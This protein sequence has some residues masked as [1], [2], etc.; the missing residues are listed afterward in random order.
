MSY[1]RIIFSCLF[2]SFFSLALTSQQDSWESIPGN[3]SDLAFGPQGY[4]YAITPDGSDLI[5]YD[6]KTGEWH[7]IPSDEAN[8]RQIEVDG[9]GRPWLL[10]EAGKIAYWQNGQWQEVKGG[11]KHLG[12]SPQG[13]VYSVSRGSGSVFRWNEG[14]QLWDPF[15]KGPS[16]AEKVWGS[17]D[18]NF[19]YTDAAGKLFFFVKQRSLSG[20]IEAQDLSW[21]TKEKSLY[22]VDPSGKLMRYSDATDK[23]HAI[24]NLPAKVKKVAVHPLTQKAWVIDETGAIWRPLNKSSLGGKITGPAG[25][26]I[27]G[28][29]LTIF[30]IGSSDERKT[31]IKTDAEG[32]WRYRTQANSV[33]VSPVKFGDFKTDARVNVKDGINESVKGYSIRVK[34]LTYYTGLNFVTKT[35]AIADDWLKKTT[36]SF[37]PDQPKVMV[38]V[39]G[40]TISEKMDLERKR[41]YALD[42]RDGNTSGRA[43]IL[44]PYEQT[45]TAAHMQFYWGY[46]F[47]RVLQGKAASDDLY[48]F[49]PVEGQERLKFTRS[50][51]DTHQRPVYPSKWT[52]AAAQ[53]GTKN[54]APLI[55]DGRT[56]QPGGIPPVSVMVLYR[57]GAKSFIEQT[58]DVSSQLYDS[59]QHYF[60]NLPLDQ[61]PA[62]YILGH[63]FGGITSR[64]LLNNS[65]AV[66]SGQGH[67]DANFRKAA[68][69]IRDRTVLLNT[70][71][72]PH[73]G[74]PVPAST[75]KTHRQVTELADAIRN[76]DNI[77]R[78]I[79]TT[80]T[81][82]RESFVTEDRN[83]IMDNLTSIANNVK[84]S[85]SLD[86][87]AS[88]LEEVADYVITGDRPVLDDIN[89]IR[90]IHDDFIT[91]QH[92]RRTDGSLIPVYTMT[93][94][95]PGSL[96]YLTE[97]PLA[98]FGGSLWNARHSLLD[99]KD[100]YNNYG[101]NKVAFESTFL[102]IQDILSGEDTW[103]RKYTDFEFG[104]R[105]SSK[106]T[107][108]LDM[109]VGCLHPEY[110]VGIGFGADQYFDSDGMVGFESG[111]ALKA[112]GHPELNYFSANREWKVGNKKE[113]G[114]WYR[115]YGKNYGITHPWDYDNHRS[116]CFNT[117]TAAFIHNYL[118]QLAGPRV[119]AGS[120]STM[121]GLPAK[122]GLKTS[123]ITVEIS[124][125]KDIR[126]NIDPSLDE[127]DFK[128]SV[129]I[130]DRVWQGG[131]V[132]EG[133][134]E[135]FKDNFQHGKPYVWTF[136]S[137]WIENSTIVPVIIRIE[138]AD[139]NLYL[140]D[141]LCSANPACGREDIVLFVDTQ[142][143]QIYGDYE[144]VANK[145]QPFSLTGH[146]D[147]QHTIELWAR[148]KV[149]HKE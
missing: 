104:D 85:E 43:A 27:E 30:P 119:A 128:A 28:V 102:A 103:T 20:G 59:Y 142:N 120:F 77:D 100:R 42:H 88:Q 12:N 83:I 3:F 4:M 54:I 53:Q 33:I 36:F 68:D 141:D 39:H 21:G 72:T 148:I 70:L 69:Y 94:S 138:D 32:R 96:F 55:F 47:I 67:F 110:G 31:T 37:R 76:L 62:I 75:Q 17:R 5:S 98:N 35:Q 26:P 136:G 48:F 81:I 124:K 8:P 60:S 89:N 149:R 86:A 22:V 78:Y 80:T 66:L 73:L 147:N 63:S 90:R 140:A 23:W 143:G 107:D 82:R 126:G 118:L 7:V 114:S 52:A 41:K 95:N 9:K 51:W 57:D 116:I 19:V 127:A 115:L 46:D 11:S 84:I 135:V 93:G 16:N 2:F 123:A 74:S 106:S 132:V 71:A 130:G 111:H 134:D 38:L 10:N 6:D 56:E 122:K 65:R 61:Q 49:P 105:F 133:E 29:E 97:R 25:R 108:M 15:V 144:G 44:Y 34:P 92:M 139:E 18:D 1:L 99:I 146:K 79:K 121:D 24:T 40:I 109:I 58:E 112:F 131:S 145:N 87:F 101:A 64:A 50:T 125:V 91:E 113:R 13:I 45:N 117:G 14:R 137:K 129:K